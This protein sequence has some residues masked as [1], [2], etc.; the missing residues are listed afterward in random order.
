MP[1]GHRGGGWGCSSASPR[2]N[3]SWLD[4]R[5]GHG[6]SKW[7]QHRDTD[8]STPSPRQVC[9]GAAGPCLHENSSSEN[10]VPESAKETHPPSASSC[11]RREVQT[12]PLARSTCMLEGSSRTATPPPPPPPPA[13]ECRNVTLLTARVHK[14]VEPVAEEG[15]E[16]S[17]RTR[18]YQQ[19]RG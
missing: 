10:P 1:Q 13:T 8:Y 16:V 4:A 17:T 15:E 7:D 19:G 3:Q 14:D 6:R 18:R 9:S 5:V 11:Q 12:P 2:T